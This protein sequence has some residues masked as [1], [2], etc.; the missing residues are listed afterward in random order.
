MQVQIRYPS[1]G[2]NCVSCLDE[3]VP[4]QNLQDILY[5]NSLIEALGESEFWDPWMRVNILIGCLSGLGWEVGKIETPGQA[6][7][8]IKVTFEPARA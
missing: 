4:E 6:T 5:H 8:V 7:D 2:P 3:N 1:H